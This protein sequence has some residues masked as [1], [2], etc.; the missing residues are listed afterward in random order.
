MDSAEE[1][2]RLLP[3]IWYILPIIVKTMTFLIFAWWVS[4]GHIDT[5]VLGEGR[6]VTISMVSFAMKTPVANTLKLESE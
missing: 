2:T 3:I 4:K 5:R 6:K 1:K